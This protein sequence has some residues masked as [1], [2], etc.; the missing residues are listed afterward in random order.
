MSTGKMDLAWLDELVA[1]FRPEHQVREPDLFEILTYGSSEQV[2]SN[3][4]AF[5]LDREAHHGFKDLFLS[6]LKTTMVRAAERSGIVQ[7][8]I[9]VI[10][11]TP[12]EVMAEVNAQGKRIDL[13]LVGQ[14]EDADA[15]DM[16]AMDEQVAPWALIIENKLYAALYNRLDVYWNSVPAPNEAKFGVVLSLKPVPEVLL[17]GGGYR[18]VNV[19]HQ[20]LAEEVKVQL[21]SYY[22]EASDR[23]LLLLKE[24]LK[25][26]A[27]HYEN[28]VMNQDHES[29]LHQLRGKEA[30]INALTKRIQTLTSYVAER[31]CHVFKEHGYEPNSQRAS[32]TTRHFY[33]NESLCKDLGAPYGPY[34]R[35]WVYL[36]DTVYNDK[37]YIHMELY[38][39]HT[40]HGAALRALIQQHYGAE[41]LQRLHLAPGSA[42]HAKTSH[43]HIASI[44]GLPLNSK[45]DLEKAI[46]ERLKHTFFSP[47]DNFMQR[48]TDWMDELT[49]AK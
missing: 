12:Y 28:Y 45:G 43:Y 34:F 35:F 49:G 5:Y 48:C 41:G 23:H 19:L 15:A 6:A 29:D 22:E 36:P 24:Y 20:E 32:G 33:A 46:R 27:N 7:Y 14:R 39:A 40:V 1:S 42:A 26:I 18:Y 3:I 4:L 9:D 38:D 16:A 21:S 30:Q 13:L 47:N 17:H 10:G 31:F 25:N 2:N 37:L 44:L 8:D 11:S